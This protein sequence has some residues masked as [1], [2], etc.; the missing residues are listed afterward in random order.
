MDAIRPPDDPDDLKHRPLQRTWRDDAAGV[1][2]VERSNGRVE[3]ELTNLGAR[4]LMLGLGV[5]T[6]R[7][8]PEVKSLLDG[9]C[10]LLIRAPHSTLETSHPHGP[11]CPCLHCRQAFR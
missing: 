10:R 8:G 6:S 3:I 7:Y 1:F 9:L 5:N 11:R 4:R 2:I